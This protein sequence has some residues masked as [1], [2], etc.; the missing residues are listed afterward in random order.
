VL[1]LDNNRKTL[2]QWDVGVIGTLAIDGVDEVHFS[3]LR[4][5]VSFNIKV[6]DNK[7]EFPPEVLQSGADVF[8]WA[9]VRKENGGYTKKEQIF[10]VEK[11]P[12]PADYVYEPTEILSWET[13]SKELGIFKEDTTEALADLEKGT[14]KVITEQVNLWELETGIYYLDG[15]W[16]YTENLGASNN[17]RHIFFIYKPTSKKAVRYIHFCGDYQKDIWSRV[18]CGYTDGTTLTEYYFIDSS[19][20][21]NDPKNDALGTKILNSAGVKNYVK[22][23]IETLKT[24][25]QGEL[26]E[27]GEL[28]G[29]ETGDS[30]VVTETI[31]TEG[32]Y[33]FDDY[34]IIGDGRRYYYHN[35]KNMPSATTAT[36]NDMFIL[37]FNGE[38]YKLSWIFVEGEPLLGNLVI[39]GAPEGSEYDTGEDFCICYNDETT[40]SFYTT[41]PKGDY[42]VSLEKIVGGA[43]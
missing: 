39:M 26:D 8:C 21:T 5:G 4:Y 42:T 30:E 14:I 17:A 9:F 22:E 11:R 41:L 40:L 10:N 32:I 18:E 34:S 3:N 37:K 13:L 15:G 33:A 28:V 25:I 16:S 12:R 19:Q 27:I 38:T 7:V 6:V 35:F 24:D 31:I 20:V 36:E 2:Y 23:S 43:E 1:K 29:G